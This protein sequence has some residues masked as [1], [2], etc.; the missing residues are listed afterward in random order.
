MQDFAA[1][2]T[3]THLSK[4]LH[5]AAGVAVEQVAGAHE[6]AL[7]LAGAEDKDARMFQIPS[8]DALDA[9]VVGVSRDAGTQTAD[10]AD[11]HFHLDAC[12]RSFNQLFHDFH[13]IKGVDL[14]EDVPFSAAAGKVNLLLDIAQDV[15]F[16][17]VGSDPQLLGRFHHLTDTQRLKDTGG[18]LTHLRVGGD[19]GKVGV[20]LGGF[21]VVVAGADLSNI[22][23]LVVY[24]AGN[25]AEL[26]VYL[27]V[28]QSVDDGAAC[29]L[30]HG[31]VVDVVLLVKARP[32][33]QYAQHLLAFFG[34]VC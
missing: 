25:Q 1:G 31:G 9:D 26:C 8:N 24:L 22:L 14:D 27:V 16:K 19:K 11:D 21:F 15:G 20:Q 7:L 13:I 32:K 3:V 34:S 18:I 28:A 29:L 10:A 12:L 4:D 5:P 30:E 17:A 23:N 2:I 6:D 33:L